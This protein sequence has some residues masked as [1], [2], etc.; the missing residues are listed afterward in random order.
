M[1]Y[2]DEVSG[3]ADVHIGHQKSVT[4][5]PAGTSM[6]W[7]RQITDVDVVKKWCCA[8]HR[9]FTATA[10]AGYHQTLQCS[11]RSFWALIPENC[12]SLFRRAA[13]VI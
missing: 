7:R 13:I 1:A 5:E 10:V 9:T 11:R 12:P 3:S 2:G 8:E 6:N 4:S